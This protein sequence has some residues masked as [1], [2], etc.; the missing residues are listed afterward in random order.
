MKTRPAQAEVPEL[1][2]SAPSP[3]EGATRGS[4]RLLPRALPLVMIP[5]RQSVRRANWE[6]GDQRECIGDKLGNEWGDMIKHI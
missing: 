2:L 3:L 5:P 4:P 1:V 6:E